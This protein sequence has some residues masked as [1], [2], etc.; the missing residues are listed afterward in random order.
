MKSKLIFAS[1]LFLLA[2]AFVSCNKEELDV[3]LAPQD[4]TAEEAPQLR[5][6]ALALPDLV[7][8]RIGSDIST[9]TTIC[10]PVLPNISCM[11]GDRFFKIS[12]LVK[13]IGP[14]DLPPGSFEVLW[15]DVT[16]GFP[17]NPNQLV[18]HNGIASGQTIRVTRPIY[19][20][21]CDCAPP[22]T[23]FTHTYQAQVDPT[24]Q[25]PEVSD[26]NNRSPQYDTCDG[27]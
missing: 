19:V 26:G 18:N 4:H 17:L 1:F 11:G 12:V 5:A 2:I 27:C 24:N 14:R 16:G 20:G 15:Y 23:S 3:E 10:G 21:P 7:I 13:N 25:I 9:T 22:F 6:A 8:P